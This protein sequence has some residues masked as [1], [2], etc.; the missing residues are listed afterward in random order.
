MPRDVHGIREVE[1]CR[2]RE[3]NALVRDFIL[4]YEGPPSHQAMM[5]HRLNYGT[6]KKYS[7]AIERARAE[8]KRWREVR[9]RQWEEFIKPQQDRRTEGPRK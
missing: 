9:L 5:T 1:A 8:E 2:R 7:N 6:V 3:V 4:D